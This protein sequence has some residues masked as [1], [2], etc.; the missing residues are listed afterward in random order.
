VIKPILADMSDMPDAVMTLATVAAF[1]SGV[2]VIRG[3][4]T[5]RFKESDRIAALRDELAKIGVAVESPVGGDEDVLR[6]VPP[7]RGVDCSSDAGAVEFRTYNDHRMAMSM[8]LIGLKRPGVLIDDPA[9]VAKTYPGF[10]ADLAMLY[11]PAIGGSDSVPQARGGQMET[12][13]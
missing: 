13:A 7:D 12:G 2:S 8:A 10:W 9:C 3:V 5:L 6:V 11:D 1:A 4:R